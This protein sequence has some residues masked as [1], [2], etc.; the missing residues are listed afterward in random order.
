MFS[1]SFERMLDRKNANI[2]LRKYDIYVT[3]DFCSVFYKDS[4]S[5]EVSDTQ[6]NILQ[7]S[8]DIFDPS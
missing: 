8:E 5:R 1:K 2:R 4:Q 7:T 3:Y 6:S